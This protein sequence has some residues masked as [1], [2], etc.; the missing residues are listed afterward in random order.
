MLIKVNG[1]YL[2]FEDTIEIEK[3]ILLFETITETTGDFSYSFELAKTTKNLS[4]LGF[5]FPDVADKT[6]FN[7]IECQLSDDDGVQLYSGKL[8][9]E[10]ILKNTIQCSFFSGNYNWISLLTGDMTELDLSAYDLDQTETNIVNSWNDTEGIIFPLLDNGA[11]I[12]RSYQSLVI[13][14]FAGAFFVKTLFK[15]VFT[16]SGLKIQGELLESFEFNNMLILTN[17]RSKRDIE[18]NSAFIGNQSPQVVPGLTFISS[19]VDIEFTDTTSPYF[20]GSD[21]TLTGLTDVTVPYGMLADIEFSWISTPDVAGTYPTCL[22]LINNVGIEIGFVAQGLAYGNDTTAVISN[23]RLRPGDVISVIAGNGFSTDVTIDFATLRIKPKYIYAAI[24]KS[25][26]PLWTKQQ[27][28][29]NIISLFNTITDYDPYT[30]TVTFNLFDKIKSRPATDISEY[31]TI[32][33][34]DYIDL[35]SSY[36]RNNLLG[37]NQIDDDSLLEYNIS[38]FVKYGDGVIEVDNDFID[39]SATV[40]ASDIS[41]PVSY[42][43]TA[44]GL[45]LEKINYVELDEIFEAEITSVTDS[46]GPRFNITDAD[47]LFSVN[48]LVSIITATGLYEGQYV[49]NS[50][51]STYITVLGLEYNGTEAGTMTKLQHNVTTDDSVYI[52]INAGQKNVT[53][54]SATKTGIYLNTALK[55]S[56]NFAFFNILLT[57]ANI[58]DQYTQG[59]SFGGYENQSSYQRNL[60]D[61]YWNLFRSILNNPVKLI[62]TGYFPKSVFMSLSFLN[63]VY[64]KTNETSN[65]YYINRISGYQKSHLPCEIELIK[66]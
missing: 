47:D 54:I 21:L 50:V 4:I 29:N 27:F 60:I 62:A 12:S 33:E 53:D 38:S 22:I 17:T 30:K 35:V 9:V 2:D 66:L 26:V 16:Q 11:L 5:P 59:L 7:N 13:E 34:V 18:N 43:N 36:G 48:D 58:E 64:I 44:F 31:I 63:P 6:I 46:S 8:R 24:G 42:V 56:I 15:E 40:V 45:S 32:D 19:P 65:L 51:T 39:E 57:G 41:A 10:K 14:D 49:V 25:C 28:V 3:Q 52:V 61:K 37:Y 23:F 1:E 20:L 55:T